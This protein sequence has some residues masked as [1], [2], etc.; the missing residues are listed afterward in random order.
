MTHTSQQVV[1]KTGT[2]MNILCYFISA[3]RMPNSQKVISSDFFFFIS[4]QNKNSNNIPQKY[5]HDFEKF[6]NEEQ[7]IFWNR[8]NSW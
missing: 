5:T 1:V 8:E 2:W 4:K 3:L 6:S 7:I